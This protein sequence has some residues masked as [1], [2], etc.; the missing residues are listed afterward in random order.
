MFKLEA[1][2]ALEGSRDHCFTVDITIVE[3][4]LV[5]LFHD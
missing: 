1:V 5:S 3:P 4:P 2:K